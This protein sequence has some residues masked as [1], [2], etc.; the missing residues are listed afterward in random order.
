MKITLGKATGF[1]LVREESYRGFLL[2]V[3]GW[4]VS[5][6]HFLQDYV[7]IPWNRI[8]IVGERKW[9]LT[10]SWKTWAKKNKHGFLYALSKK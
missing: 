1:E 3:R 7:G 6:V 9:W 8:L 4:E 2:M 5:Y 10:D